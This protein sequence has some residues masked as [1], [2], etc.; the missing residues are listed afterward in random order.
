MVN[1]NDT[2]QLPHILQCPKCGDVPKPD[3]S[4]SNTVRLLC[5]ACVFHG[6]CAMTAKKAIDEWNKTCNEYMREKESA[7]RQYELL[8]AAVGEE[9]AR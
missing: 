4:G 9:L 1:T 2:S 7:D 6:P 8:L 3:M 5:E